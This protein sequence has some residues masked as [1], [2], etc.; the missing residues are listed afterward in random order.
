MATDL[1]L[2]RDLTVRDIQP[3]CDADAIAAFFATLGYDTSNR[4]EQTVAAMPFL[5]I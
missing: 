3:L 4:I 1:V 5:P 2:D